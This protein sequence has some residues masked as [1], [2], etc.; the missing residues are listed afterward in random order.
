MGKRELRGGQ[1]V[2]QSL[3]QS[4]RQKDGQTDRELDSRTSWLI[5]CL[6][7]AATIDKRVRDSH[8]ES[9]LVVV[10]VNGI[11]VNGREQKALER[12]RKRGKGVLSVLCYSG[13]SSQT[14]LVARVT[15]GRRSRLKENSIGR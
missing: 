6:G 14:L 11:D 9:A 10:V 5:I 13:Q 8:I 4:I 12:E 3:S 7:L 2:S 1:P 15:R